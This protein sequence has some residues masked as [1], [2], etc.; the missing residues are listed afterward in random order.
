VPTA[1]ATATPS[2]PFVYHEPTEE[3]KE[4][5]RRVKEQEE[6]ARAF[7]AQSTMPSAVAKSKKPALSSLFAPTVPGTVATRG[8]FIKKY[9]GYKHYKK[10][11]RTSKYS[12]ARKTKK[13]C[14]K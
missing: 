2:V 11:R 7:M 5:D 9:K 14:R 10:S 1:T 4:E 12:K 8:R 3:E 13:R 6:Q